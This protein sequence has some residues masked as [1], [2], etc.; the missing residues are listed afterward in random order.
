MALLAGHELAVQVVP[1][2]AVTIRPL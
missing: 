1:G 2:G